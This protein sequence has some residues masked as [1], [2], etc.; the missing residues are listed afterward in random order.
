MLAIQGLKKQLRGIRST[1]KLTKAMRTVSTVKFSKLNDIYSEYSKYGKQCRK[2]C[3]QF[4]PFFLENIPERNPDAPSAVIVMTSNK[5]LCG[6]FNTEIL[7]FAEAQ[8]SK[9]DSFL[10]VACGKKA[11]HYFKTKERAIE[12]ECVWGDIPTYE[13]SNALLEEIL[14]WRK[15]GKISRVY[16]IY[17]KYVNMMNQVPR[18]SEL[19][20]VENDT[21]EESVLFMPDKNTANKNIAIVVFRAM[22]Y[23][24]IL[25]TAVGAQAATL[26]T[27]RAAYDTATE[28]YEELEKRINRM[29]QSAVTADVIE[30]SAEQE[31]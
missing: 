13:E 5:G 14:T 24:Y 31:E 2:I 4:G 6:K 12:K 1:K 8:L 11:I 17:P 20:S 10:L 18:I 9:M 25:E 29:R 28:Y 27:M 3:K 23:E 21:E 22:F 16:V 26:L 7:E 19:F 15:E 30:T